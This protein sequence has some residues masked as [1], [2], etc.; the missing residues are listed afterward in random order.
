MIDSPY[1]SS[2]QKTSFK[3]IPFIT[4]REKASYDL[5][6]WFAVSSVWNGRREWFP[7]V[8]L[9]EDH[10]GSSSQKTASGDMLLTDS[11]IP[12]LRENSYKFLANC[13]GCTNT[14]RSGPSG[15]RHMTKVAD[16]I[17]LMVWHHLSCT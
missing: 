10:L 4:M 12:G 17:G 11:C 6:G 8:G 5:A 14:T 7:D 9:P 15:F 2:F 3:K 16:S 1:D 13:L